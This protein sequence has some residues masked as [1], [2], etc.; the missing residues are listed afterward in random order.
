MPTALAIYAAALGQ[1]TLF[2][3]STWTLATAV[4]AHVTEVQLGFPRLLRLRRPNVVLRAGPVPLSASCDLLGRVEDVDDPR[5]WWRLE[6][7]RRLLV[8]LGPWLATFAVAVACLGPARAGRSFGHAAEQLLWTVDLT[9]LVRRFVAL[10]GQ[11]P[12]AITLGVV[13][14][15]TTFMNLLPLPSLA[16][17]QALSELRGRP[18]HPA[19]A[20]GSMLAVL[21]W[22]GG[23]IAYA[24]VRTVL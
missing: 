20:I 16:G 15:K 2:V 18:A 24:V 8:M 12:F 1:A 23:R 22:F 7:P 4:G 9:P 21:V 17:G 11:A 6:L 13:C 10:V 14:A 5:S 19:W 3:A